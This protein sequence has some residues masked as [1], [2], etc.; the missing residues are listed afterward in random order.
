MPPDLLPRSLDQ[1]PP[2][3]GSGGALGGGAQYAENLLDDFAPYVQTGQLSVHLYVDDNLYVRELT[4]QTI[5]YAERSQ[6]EPIVVGDLKNYLSRCGPPTK[7]L[8]LSDSPDLVT[9]LLVK[10]KTRYH[11][12]QL[13]LTKS[14]ATFFEATNP[15]ANKGT[16][17]KYLAEH[18]LNLQPEQVMAIGDNFN[19]LE[20]IQYAGIGVAMGNAPPDLKPLAD[21][22]APDVE[23]DGAVAAYRKIYPVCLVFVIFKGIA[24]L[25]TKI[26]RQ[27]R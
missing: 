8:A 6:V 18:I 19:D 23:S 11:Q 22:V 17:V 10:L 3:R 4:P 27:Y 25:L 5:A 21:W 1:R 26:Q 15:L 12:G 2:D 24:Q 9:E 14:V 20:M 7:V 13:Y 16:A